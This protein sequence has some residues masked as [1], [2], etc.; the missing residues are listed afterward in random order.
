MLLLLLV[1]FLKSLREKNL[2]SILTH[3][4]STGL[5]KQLPLLGQILPLL[6][7][8]GRQRAYKEPVE[9]LFLG[10]KQ[11]EHNLAYTFRFSLQ[12]Q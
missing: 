3:T 10:M 12:D 1:V 7:V 9:P 11:T 6:L 5:I 8:L 2:N 4:T